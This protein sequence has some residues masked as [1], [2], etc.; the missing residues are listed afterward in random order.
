MENKVILNNIPGEFTQKELGSGMFGTCY[1]TKD[2]RVFKKFFSPMDNYD[3]L[4]YIS[5]YYKSNHLVLPEQ[6]V[7]LNNDP[8][9]YIGYIREYVDGK[10]FESLSDCIE[11]ERFIKAL[12][13]IEKE[14]IENVKKGLEYHDTHSENLLYTPKDEIKII[15]SDL[16]N[17]SYDYD[18]SERIGYTFMD[19]AY[20]INNKVLDANNVNDAI[21]KLISKSYKYYESG[22]IKPSQLMYELAMELKRLTGNENQTLGDMRNSLKL[23][24]GA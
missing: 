3:V 23:V 24:K 11:V 15:D 14:I 12:Q 10:N 17:I 19:I 5:N 7:F 21:E 18:Y 22:F 1:L 2:G 8:K 16:F 4:S 20:S 13:S 9:N 6:F